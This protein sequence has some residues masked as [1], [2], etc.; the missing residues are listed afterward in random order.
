MICMRRIKMMANKKKQLCAT[1]FNVDDFIRLYLSLSKACFSSSSSSA[2]AGPALLPLAIRSAGE[3]I[4][5]NCTPL[6]EACKGRGEAMV[7]PSKFLPLL[8]LVKEDWCC[9]HVHICR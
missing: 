3:L 4:S 7:W 2:L 6:D 5:D 9:L 1:L 8:L